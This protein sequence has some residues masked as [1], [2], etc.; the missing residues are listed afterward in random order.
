MFSISLAKVC[1]GAFRVGRCTK[2]V[3]LTDSDQLLI[4]LAATDCTEYRASLDNFVI[5]VAL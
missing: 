2:L 5:I 1:L 3:A 4:N